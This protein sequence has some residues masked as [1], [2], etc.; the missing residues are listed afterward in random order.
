MNFILNLIKTEG[1]ILINFFCNIILFIIVICLE[2][3][4]KNKYINNKKDYKNI[5]KIVKEVNN[6]KAENE[7]LKDCYKKVDK[8][9]SGAIQKVK[10][11][12]Y[13]AFENITGNLSFVI[14]LLDRKNSGIILNGIYSLQS[15]NIYAK[16]IEKGKSK[17]ELSEEEKQALK[18]IL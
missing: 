7:K 9:I 2:I 10:I 15:F 17:F 1:F 5:K 11:I 14:V 16:L 13:N 8:D 4:N 12:K 3:S 18:E 6:I